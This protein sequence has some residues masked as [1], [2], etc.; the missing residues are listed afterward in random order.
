MAAPVLVP[1]DGR[2]NRVAQPTRGKPDHLIGIQILRGLAASAVALHH[3][4]E[5]SNGVPGRFSPDWLTT[6]GA[7]GVDIFF[8]ISGFIMLH[9]SFPDVDK[10]LTPSSFLVRR[11]LRIYPFY[12]LCN[13]AMLALAV[14]GFLR[15][16]DHGAKTILRSLL[17]LP[18]DHYLLGV[19]W[20][21]VYEIY[22][23]ILF[24]ASL[25]AR[26]IIAS[27]VIPSVMILGLMLASP[28]LPSGAVRD[29]LGNPIAVEFC[30]GLGLNLVWRRHRFGGRLPL[31]L[32]GIGALA[33]ALAP[34]VFIPPSTNGLLPARRIFA[35]GL[36][37]L[38]IVA[39]S[40]RPV[41]PR[42]LVRA[43]AIVG[44]ASYSIYL[45]HIFL[46][47]AYG[48]LLRIPAVG[49]MPQLFLVFVVTLSCVIVGVACHFAV[50]KPT[51]NLLHKAR[52]RRRTSAL[53]RPPAVGDR[54][55]EAASP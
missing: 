5:M 6:A 25:F 37:A 12:W 36:P 31:V 33:L 44:D 35:W 27:V 10:P 46:M 3:S 14:A 21:L 11:A 51:L 28:L 2:G 47:I 54:A 40:L 19:A 8:V 13:L 42:R 23:Y 7:A 29:F 4:L 55:E 48:W 1:A 26:S 53:I 22:F 16:Q 18:G 24:A 50:E 17:L 43:A 38:L 52:Q 30:L 49:Q 20:T 15:H 34:L 9:V 41:H 32:G 45:S 39:A